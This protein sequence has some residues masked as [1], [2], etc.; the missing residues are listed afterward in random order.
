VVKLFD[1]STAWLGHSM[2]SDSHQ[3]V[4]LASCG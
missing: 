1:A 2:P 3:T 4:F